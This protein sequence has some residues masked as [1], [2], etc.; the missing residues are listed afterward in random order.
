MDGMDPRL[1]LQASSSSSP[2]KPLER[3]PEIQKMLLDCLLLLCQSRRMRERLRQKKVYPILRNLDL[4]IE[5]DQEAISLVIL[6]VVNFLIG[7]E[8]PYEMAE[9]KRKEQE[10][11][12]KKGKQLE[13]ATAI[14]QLEGERVGGKILKVPVLIE[15]VLFT[16]PSKVVIKG[17]H[18]QPPPQEVDNRWEWEDI[19]TVDEV[20]VHFQFHIALWFFVLS[21]GELG[22]VQR[23]EVVGL[24]FFVEGHR[25]SPHQDTV[26]NVSLLGGGE[27][28]SL[29]LFKPM[30]VLTAL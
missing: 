19:I 3:N 15:E 24:R 1:W 5:E 28:L 25:P 13:T 7:D 26:Y 29:P 20:H 14:T 23:V 6:D 10:E 12:E 8:D 21:F 11:E 30:C 16:F 27:T 2:A 18:V 9:E 17:V 22:V 4:I